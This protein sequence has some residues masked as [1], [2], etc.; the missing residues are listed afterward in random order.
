V[1]PPEAS[2]PA[3]SAPRRRGRPAGASAKPPENAQL[4]AAVEFISVV[5]TEAFELSQYAS[6][7]NQQIIAYSNIIAAGHPIAEE[8]NLCPQIEKMKAALMRCGKSLAITENNGQISIKGDKLRALVPCMA[9]PLAP[10]LPDP[11]VLS[12]D[13]DALKEAF[14]V[15]GVVADEASERPMYASLLL[16][17]DTLTATNGKVLIQYWHGVKGLPPGTVIPK[18]FAAAIAKQKYKITGIGAAWNGTFATSVTFWFENGSWVKTQCYE[19]RWQDFNHV[20]NV[21]TNPVP[22][23]TGLFDAIAAIEPFCGQSGAVIF[24]ENAVA[25]HNEEDTGAIYEVKGLP[26]GKVFAAKLV[27]QV[28]P[29]VKTID[30][31]SSPD[32]G[33]FFGGETNH[34]VRGVFMGMHGSQ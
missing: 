13:F 15:C 16:E 32:R 10:V 20:I 14:K 26:A 5:S 34:P 21:Q 31:T 24:K 33:F 25:S 27:R 2:A 30:I 1:P 8:L 4:L 23:Y 11:P 3:P 9:E 7:A 22:I 29:Y 28:S 12:G 6:L 17:S 18:V 19:E